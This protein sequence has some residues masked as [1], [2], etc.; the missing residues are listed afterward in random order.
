MIYAFIL[1]QYIMVRHNY[2]EKQL[3]EVENVL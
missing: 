2:F 3:C 1:F